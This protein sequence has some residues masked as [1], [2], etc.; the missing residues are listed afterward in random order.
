MTRKHGFLIKVSNFFPSLKHTN[1]RNQKLCRI[2]TPLEINIF[3]IRRSFQKPIFS[4]KGIL[5]MA[6]HVPWDQ[7][8]LL[9]RK[10]Y[11]AFLKF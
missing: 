6:L 4:E 3:N 2:E 5:K 10:I 8:S 9:N 7:N 1:M 11:T